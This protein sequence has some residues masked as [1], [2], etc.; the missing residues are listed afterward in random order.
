[1]ILT[2]VPLISAMTFGAYLEI[3]GIPITSII[4][5]M[6]FFFFLPPQSTPTVFPAQIFPALEGIC[7]LPVSDHLSVTADFE[8]YS[9]ARLYYNSFFVSGTLG[10]RYTSNTMD[11]FLGLPGP[12]RAFA[13]VNGGGLLLVGRNTLYPLA[14]ADVGV[15]FK[16]T[17]TID[18]FW[19]LKFYYSL[20]KQISILPLSLSAGVAF[21]F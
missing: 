17:N 10:I 3:S 14:T 9:T 19:D 16:L 12:L 4:T 15:L 5:S 1:M 13:G 6:I 2:L 18:T 7:V 21:N 11:S 20:W 8:G